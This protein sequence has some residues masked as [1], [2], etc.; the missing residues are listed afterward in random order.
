MRR[1]GQL[2]AASAVRR[3]LSSHDSFVSDGGHVFNE[4]M[5]GRSAAGSSEETDTAT[6][7]RIPETAD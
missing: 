2:G 5:L 6:D 4:A 3:R 1:T 7:S